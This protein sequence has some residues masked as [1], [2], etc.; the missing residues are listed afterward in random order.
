VVYASIWTSAA[1]KAA[2]EVG[3]DIMK[4]AFRKAGSRFLGKLLIR[5]KAWDKAFVH[6]AEHFSLKL[7][8]QKATHGVFVASLRNRAAL[9]KMIIKTVKGPSRKLIS[10][11]TVDGVKA[12]RPGEGIAA[13]V[14]EIGALL[15][16]HF[17]RRDD[18]VN[19]LPDDVETRK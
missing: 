18:D 3:K 12:G 10:R 17:P 14:K 8:S 2:A 16:R 7:V 15:A 5:S 19:E 6:I 1:R 11:A 4:G 9:E 13:A